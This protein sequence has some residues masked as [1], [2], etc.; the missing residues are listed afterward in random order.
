MTKPEPKQS[1]HP[2]I[3]TLIPA[4]ILGA[5][6][7]GSFLLIYMTMSQSGVGQFPSLILAFCL[8]PTIIAI[9]IGFYILFGPKRTN[10][11]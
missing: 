7:I 2:I 11:D 8:P 6:G 3:K 5:I 1:T 9:L 10:I 4:T